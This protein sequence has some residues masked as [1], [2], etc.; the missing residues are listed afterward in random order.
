MRKFVV[1]AVAAVSALAFAASALASALP[2]NQA[3]QFQGA[4]THVWNVKGG[5]SPHDTNTKA[6]RLHVVDPST[7]GYVVAYSKRSIHIA[8]DAEAVANLS[9]EYKQT[10]HVGAGAPRISVE[11]QNGDVAYLSASYCDHAIGSDWGRADFTRFKTNCSIWVAGVAVRGR[12]YEVGV[13]RLHRRSSRSDRRAGVPRRRRVG[14]ISHRSTLAWRRR[15][16]YGRQHRREGLHDRRG[17][18]LRDVGQRAATPLRSA[19][20]CGGEVER[21]GGW[22]PP[23]ERMQHEQV[24]EGPRDTAG[25]V[26][27]LAVGASL[28]G[29]NDQARLKEGGPLVL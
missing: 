18:L 1:T 5:D 14:P 2:A 10:T 26:T 27:L 20:L 29:G 3:L 23:Q 22:A 24:E 7:G 11:F 8:T 28:A 6:L 16:V 4:G 15:D 9:F 19:S 13:A 21:S 17:L 12:R 25:S